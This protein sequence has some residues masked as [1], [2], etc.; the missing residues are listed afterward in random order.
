MADVVERLPFPI[1]KK[2]ASTVTDIVSRNG[3][4]I[5]YTIA[6]IPFR[7]ATSPDMPATFET[8]PG[9]K[10]QQD[11]EPE[12]GEQTFSGWWLRSQASW[13]EGAGAR[14]PETSIGQG[15]RVSATAGFYTSSNVDVWTPGELK[16]LRSAAGTVSST[17]Q[18]VAVVPVSTAFSVVAGRVGA[19]VRYTDLDAGS[20][21]TDLYVN[22]SV[23]FGTV[24]A[25]EQ[26]WFAAG[27]DGK[28]YS[29]PIGSTTTTPKIWTLTGAGAGP[30]RIGWAKHRLWATN[31][32]RIYAIDYSTPGATAS[33]Y[34]HPS[35]AWTYT[36]IADVT[37]GVLFAGYGDGSS[38]LQ[39]IALN[40]DGSV[41]VLSA[42][43]TLAV[44][45][46][47][48][49]AL[50]CNS[51]T[52]SLVCILT[53]MGVRVAKAD[54]SGNLT[55]GPLFLQ[56][57]QE[58]PETAKP[59]LKSAGRFWWVSFGDETKLWRIDSSTEVEDTV[60]AYASDMQVSSSSNF[61]GLSVRN[62]RPV[63]VSTAGSIYF[64]NATQLCSTG[65]IQ[66]GRIKYRTDEMKTYHYVNVTAAPLQGSVSLDFLNDADTETRVLTWSTPGAALVPA[67]IPNQLGAQRFASVKLTLQPSAT[68]ITTGPRISGVRVKALPAQRPQRIYT[69][70]FECYDQEQW[71]TGQRE[72]Y[73]GFAR[74][75][76]LAVRA[77][78]DAGGVVLLVNYMFPN[79]SGE[80]CKIEG[81]KFIQFQQP[82]SVTLDGGF[83]GVLA[84]TLR[85]L[86]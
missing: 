61:V 35:T 5:H 55:Y 64:M 20:V 36:D 85:T 38:H 43:T 63:V 69:I 68:D 10:L 15:L 11:T 18:C 32:N 72:G 60:Y 45:P 33:T 1:S 77:A 14:Y 78:E 66:T 75:R 22:A 3:R 56:R 57:S 47:D 83:G 4:E 82:D 17:N 50:R 65:F 74:D 76:Y 28:V 62:E 29:G 42:A 52:G 40:T 12:A 31:G 19:V 86:T 59:S 46:S 44:L 27:N 34:N 25:T 41:P 8:A 16:L 67:Q 48:E 37:G 6:G 49:K 21:T 81:A 9:E 2:L 58:V 73:E 51:L 24:V 80:L 79:P 30:T 13:H 39:R 54:T 26:E 23:T 84:V 53:N 71:S 70:P 7:L